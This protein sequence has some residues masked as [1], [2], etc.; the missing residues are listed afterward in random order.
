MEE[1][2]YDAVSWSRASED[3]SLHYYGLSL[4]IPILYFN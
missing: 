4:F 3:K 2:I 1:A